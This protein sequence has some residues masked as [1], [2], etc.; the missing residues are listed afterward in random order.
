MQSALPWVGLSSHRYLLSRDRS[1]ILG[2]VTLS[3]ACARALAAG[4]CL[5]A[6]LLSACGAPPATVTPSSSA[7]AAV[8]PTAAPTP[9]AGSA[10]RTNIPPGWQT[11]AQ[12][13]SPGG[14]GTVLMTLVAPDQST[15]VASTTA[16]P[17]ADDQLALYLA[18]IRPAGAT[19]VSQDEPVDVDGVSGVVMT[20]V[21][22][23]PGVT[24]RENEVM[25]VNQAGNTYEITLSTLPANFSSDS[26]GLQEV[27]DSW[28]WA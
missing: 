3:S 14:G 7:S 20:Y 26:P 12:S 4:A 8:T 17:V 15:I 27:L 13:T 10:F 16:Q 22:S 6:L 23:N 19:V 24:A 5:S 11:A 1:A 18:G 25:V 2:D 9:F 28:S 21:G